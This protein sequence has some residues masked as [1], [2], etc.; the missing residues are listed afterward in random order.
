MLMLW[1]CA[2]QSTIEHGGHFFRD[3]NTR[4]IMTAFFTVSTFTLGMAPVCYSWD[5]FYGVAALIMFLFPLFYNWQIRARSGNWKA[6]YALD[7]AIGTSMAAMTLCLC[8]VNHPTWN[9][10]MNM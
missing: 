2:S 1:L 6:N 7:F 9:V 5:M 4:R 10:Q 3:N 8:S